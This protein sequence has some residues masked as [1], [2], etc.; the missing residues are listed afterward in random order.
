VVG[1]IL[2]ASPL[3][4]SRNKYSC[5]LRSSSRKSC[6]NRKPLGSKKSI[7]RNRFRI[8]SWPSTKTKSLSNSRS[9]PRSSRRTRMKWPLKMEILVSILRKT[10]SLSVSTSLSSRKIKLHF[11]IWMSSR[12]SWTHKLA[13]RH[14]RSIKIE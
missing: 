2:K 13:K 12:T 7:N 5:C 4:K 1:W 6:S 8:T 10:N 9:S 11:T 3:L 14:S